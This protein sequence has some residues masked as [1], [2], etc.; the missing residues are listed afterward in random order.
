MSKKKSFR[1][2]LLGFGFKRLQAHRSGVTPYHQE[3]EGWFCE[4]YEDGYAWAVGG[5]LKSNIAY[6]GGTTFLNSE[7]MR[8]EFEA[9]AA[10]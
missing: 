7:E 5:N 10:A 9:K 3:E 4:V 6:P 8:E 1:Q 2:V